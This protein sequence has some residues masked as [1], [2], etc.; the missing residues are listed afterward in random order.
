MQRAEIETIVLAAL[1]N[2]NLARQ[3]DD[4]LTVSAT[5]PIFGADSPL[6]SLG[7]VTLLIDIEEGLGDRGLEV[8]LSDAQAMSA[9]R[10]P[11]RDVPS[12]VSYISGRLAQ[13]S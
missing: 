11:F 9:T 13:V 5:A 6:D 1:R 3:P 12:L 10:S 4:Q 2:V 8:V 7:L